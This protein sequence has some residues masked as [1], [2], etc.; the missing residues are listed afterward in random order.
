MGFR[1]GVGSYIRPH[2]DGI[3][4]VQ[5]SGWTCQRAGG[6]GCGQASER[7]VSGASTRNGNP[8]ARFHNPL[9]T[10]SVCES[11]DLDA[12]E[13]VGEGAGYKLGGGGGGV[14]L[15]DEPCAISGV[16]KLVGDAPKTKGL[17][18]R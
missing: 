10:H 14:G 5:E 15:V 17:A 6:L 11:G 9:R 12:T 1:R 18:S 8:T 3:R 13:A 7:Q 4:G 2:S 16:S